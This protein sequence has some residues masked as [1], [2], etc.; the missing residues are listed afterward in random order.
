MRVLFLNPPSFDDFDG[1][2]GSRYQATREVRSFWYP[3]WL[4]YPAG[5]L[6]DSRIV[7][8]PAAGLSVDETLAIA[9]DYELVVFY[10][11][12]PSLKNDIQTASRIKAE[13]PS[14]LIGFVGPHPSVLPEET[15]RASEAIDFVV[16]K[17]FD[18]AVPEIAQGWDWSKVDGVS[19]RKEGRIIH[20]RERSPIEDLDRLPFVADVYKRDLKVTDYEIPWMRYPYVSVYTGRGCPSRCTFCL[21]PQTFSGHQYRM[22]TPDNVIEEVR[23]IVEYFPETN[24]VFFD[25]DTFTADRPRAREI[26]RKMARFGKSWGV[27]AKA[28]V[29]YETLKVMRDSGLRVMVI[30]YESGNQTILNNVKKGIQLDQA[31]EFTKNAKSLGITIHGTFILGLPGETPKTIDESIQYARDLD[32]DTIQVSLASPYPGTLFYDQCHENE[33][34]APGSLVSDLGYQTCNVQYPG[35]T[36]NEIFQAVE[37]FYRRFYFRPRTIGRILKKAV[38]D[39]REAKRVLTEGISFLKFMAKRRD[40]VQ[41]PS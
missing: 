29:D 20:N 23:R 31:R 34:F 2:A 18:H 6:P 14:S 19:Y 27:N 21:W 24:E 25:D 17:E 12:T 28:D 33:W 5:M 9:R 13:R 22:R 3:T 26:S 7:D 11:S 30:G 1:G 41:K 8:A 39:R 15:L 36:S 35:L 38:S 10:T 32:I 37:R 40:L 16:R 4:C